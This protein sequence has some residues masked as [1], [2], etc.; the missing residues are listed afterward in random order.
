MKMLANP[1]SIP[2]TCTL[3]ARSASILPKRSFINSE[4][5]ACRLECALLITLESLVSFNG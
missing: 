2:L 5:E 4:A 3:L 1:I